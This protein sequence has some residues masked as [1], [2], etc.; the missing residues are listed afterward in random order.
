MYNRSD[1]VENNSLF[2]TKTIEF[3]ATL[4]ATDYNNNYLLCIRNL[5]VDSN[6]MVLLCETYLHDNCRI[7]YFEQRTICLRGLS[8]ILILINLLK[9]EFFDLNFFNF[10]Y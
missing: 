2:K 5:L 10:M 4:K 1:V 9:T 3:L 7:N 8:S 6:I